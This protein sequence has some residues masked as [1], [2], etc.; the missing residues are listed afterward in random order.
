MIVS[1]TWVGFCK[2]RPTV[3]TL[4]CWGN[5]SFNA[6]ASAGY[7]SSTLPRESAP[8][9]GKLPG[10]DSDGEGEGR[11]FSSRR[12]S[13]SVINLWLSFTP[14]S[15]ELFAMC[16]PSAINFSSIASLSFRALSFLNSLLSSRLRLV[17]S[18]LVS[19]A[20]TPFRLFSRSSQLGSLLLRLP[21]PKNPCSQSARMAFSSVM[22]T[23]RDSDVKTPRYNCSG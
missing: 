19:L 22:C 9:R 16:F 15:A 17:T 7:T 14:P 2:P 1:A 11:S 4:P 6:W 8:T 13:E 3:T 18:S 23:E 20:R 21:L 5:G 10:R 12:F